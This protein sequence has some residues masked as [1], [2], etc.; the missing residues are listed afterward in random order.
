MRESFEVI[1]RRQ[2]QHKK[3]KG[4]SDYAKQNKKYIF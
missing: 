1:G 3:K 4:T 2:R